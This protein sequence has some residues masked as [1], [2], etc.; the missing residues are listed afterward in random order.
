MDFDPLSLRKNFV[1]TFFGNV[2]FAGGKWLIIVVLAKLGSPEMIGNISLGI[3][4]ST[5]VLAFTDL[6]LRP[7]IV[8]DVKVNYTFEDYFGLRLITTFLALL[9]ISAITF[10]GNYDLNTALVILIIGLDKSAFSISNIFYALF[11]QQHRMER[12]AVS[13][14]LK[15][16]LSLVTLTVIIYLTNN[17]IYG[18][19]AL[20]G[21][22][23]LIMLCY[24]YPTGTAMLGYVQKNP[25]LSLSEKIK[26]YMSVRPIYDY[27]KIIKIIRIALPLGLG[28]MLVSLNANIPRYFI[29]AYQGNRA[30]GI[31]T[32]I[33]APTAA[34]GI[35][36][37]ALGQSSSRHLAEYYAHGNI[38][39]FRTLLFKYLAIAVLM[40]MAGVILVWTAGK[41]ILMIL[42]RPEYA[43]Y[44]ELFLGIMVVTGLSY[45]SGF[46]G[47]A[48]TATRSFKIQMPLF[49]I[50]SLVTAI[51]CYWLIPNYGLLGAAFAL[52]ISQSVLFSLS[53]IIILTTLKS[54]KIS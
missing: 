33:A 41:E 22:S 20:A 23:L 27:Q 45:L 4:I 3:A 38:T 7:V 2:I 31:F 40:G 51:N 53:F 47:Y 48:I 11:Q 14:I 12:I 16:I 29:E 39:A 8:T 9:I 49:G 52:I 34:G 26:R 35:L 25:R 13:L 24:D 36:V 17:I 50:V 30:L 6:Q 5:P 44:P 42:Y 54:V 46:C 37:N 32:A 21:S 43:E 15:S 19:L 28:M 18:C 10:L 1:W